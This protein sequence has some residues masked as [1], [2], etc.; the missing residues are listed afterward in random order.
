MRVVVSYYKGQKIIE[1]KCS[2]S[3]EYLGQ[4]TYLRPSSPLLARQS[5]GRH[6]AQFSFML[7]Q[8][9]EKFSEQSTE[10]KATYF[11]TTFV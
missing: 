5:S 7:A 6:E 9:I 1:K 11:L 10:V 4:T 2:A 3:E 8:P